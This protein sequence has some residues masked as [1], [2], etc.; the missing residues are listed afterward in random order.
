VTVEGY[1]ERSVPEPGFG[2]RNPAEGALTI[3][4][5]PDLERIAPQFDGEVFG[6][7]VHLVAQDPPPCGA[8]RRTVAAPRPATKHP[9]R[10]DRHELSRATITSNCHE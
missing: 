9:P 8:Q 2:P 10:S 6:M 5:V 1:L 3:A 7:L 4:Q